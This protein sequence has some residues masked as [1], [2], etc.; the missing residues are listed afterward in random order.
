MNSSE[1]EA[2]HDSIVD[3][4]ITLKLRP[5]DEVR[6]SSRFFYLICWL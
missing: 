5:T 4:Y 2:L 1:V 3:L 6:I